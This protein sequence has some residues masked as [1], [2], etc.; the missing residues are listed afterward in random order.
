VAASSQSIS[1]SKITTG[2]DAATAGTDRTDIPVND[3]TAIDTAAPIALMR[4][5]GIP[6]ASTLNAHFPAEYM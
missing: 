1:E 6:V 4:L 5:I 3:T 2:G